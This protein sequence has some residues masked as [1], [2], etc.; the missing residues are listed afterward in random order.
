MGKVAASRG[1]R[2]QA[3]GVIKKTWQVGAVRFNARLN[4]EALEYWR[5]RKSRQHTSSFGDFCR[6]CDTTDVR[7]GDI[8]EHELVYTGAGCK[9]SKAMSAK[10]TKGGTDGAAFAPVLTSFNN[11]EVP[12]SN[13]ISSFFTQPNRNLPGL[14]GV[15]SILS[16]YFRHVVL[17]GMDAS[18]KDTVFLKLNGFM[19]RYVLTQINSLRCIGNA[20]DSFAI[21]EQEKRQRQLACNMGG[22]V[23]LKVDED[24]CPGDTV[25]AD[26]P[27][28]DFY[29]CGLSRGESPPT[30]LDVSKRYG[31]NT[32]D[33]L[34]GGEQ[35]VPPNKMTLLLRPEKAVLAEMQEDVARI[36][37]DLLAFAVRAGDDG[38]QVANN[39]DDLAMLNSFRVIARMSVG[40]DR[41]HPDAAF[42]RILGAKGPLGLAIAALTPSGHRSMNSLAPWS[43][44]V[45]TAGCDAPGAYADIRMTINDSTRIVVPN[46][47]SRAA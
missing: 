47:P 5:N 39:P 18:T 42:L 31:P 46:R 1:R 16:F 25:V 17:A 12:S 20:Q 9:G 23:T 37:A 21:A 19:M 41:R 24:V 32:A 29:D 8:V 22:L 7:V 3:P 36:D 26:L 28:R 45:C 38:A 13:T 14:Q 35:F 43:I 40:A 6:D 2:N 33:R 27:V 30:G 15:H 4:S 11:M 34:A 44:G 10:A